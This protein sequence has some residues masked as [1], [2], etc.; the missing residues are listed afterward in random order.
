[1][2]TYVALACVAFWP[3]SPWD[4]HQLPACN[5]GDYAKMTAFLEWTPWAILHGHNPFFTTYQD[6]P[7]GVNLALNT[8]M[9]T[10]GI[11]LAPVTLTA[12]PI[13]AM[14][15]LAR[16]ELAGSAI[17]AFLVFRRWVRWTP[18]AALGGLLFGFS[19]YVMAHAEG[20]PNL[21]FVVLLPVL[22]LL[23]DEVV[24][25]Q[26][27]QPRNAGLLLGLVAAAQY[28][29]SSEV[30]A[31]GA[32]IAIGAVLVLAAVNWDAVR[33]HLPYL[34]RASGWS[35]ASFLPLAGY[36]IVEGLVGPRHLN[37]PAQVLTNLNGLHSDLLG[38][39]LPT[40]VQLFSL[41]RLGT[42]G[43]AFVSHSLPENATYVGVPLLVLLV[44]ATIAYR[45]DARLVF[46][47]VAAAAVYVV[48]L[49]SRLV[50]DGRATDLALP[51]RLLLHV[52]LLQ[53][54]ISIR[55]FAYGY[56]FVAL[57]LAVAL[58]HLRDPASRPAPPAAPGAG[59]R[60]LLRPALALVAGAATLLPLV[61]RLPI[62]HL[63]ADPGAVFGSYPVPAFFTAG[64][65]QAIPEG[66][67]VL[68]YPYSTAGY[69]NYSVLWQAV[70]EERFRLTS[71]DATV[72]RPNGIGGS[73]P[74]LHPPLLEH[75]LTAAYLGH[76]ALSSLPLDASEV[77][78]IR[79][80]L[81]AYGFSTVVV[82]A[83]GRHPAWVLRAMAAVLGVPPAQSG[84]VYVWYGVQQ[85]LRH[86]YLDA[87]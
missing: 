24:V 42:V 87:S 45:R 15:V 73:S 13:A 1:V 28:G 52:P 84:G 60:R 27:M 72:P 62:P 37:G 38:A 4:P 74:L 81:R 66:S 47:S 23:V 33:A 22:L 61:P 59:R 26:A 57:G 35:L 53:S 41:G 55:F 11:L 54:A 58:D 19:P 17:T 50:V 56:L 71:G 78:V 9:P 67:P 79:S 20:H 2:A 10:L 5:C 31:D 16:V 30:L 64:G 48:S 34:A 3:I 85:D 86:E 46:C 43:S 12:G 21:V 18:A 6:Y 51:F 49:G 83:V 7:A 70:G 76:P 36:P 77:A 63:P 25:R 69:L 68:V 29:I 82:A 44:G 80:T 40:R 32:L 8:T 39:V 14:N 75:L 65:E